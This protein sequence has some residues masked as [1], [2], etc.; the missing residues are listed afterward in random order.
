MKFS[1]TFAEAYRALSAN[2]VR[3]GLTVLGIVIGIGSVIALVAVGTGSQQSITQSIE[4]IGANLLMVQPGFQSGGA[5][6][7]RQAR[8]SAQTL[9]SADAEAIATLN[10][11]AA[12]APEVN[13]RYQVV[14]SQGNAN[15]QVIATVPAYASVRMVQM[16]QGTFLS[17]QDVANATRVVVLG[18]QAAIDLFGDPADGGQDPLG[19]TVRIKN[20]RFTVVGVTLSK[21]GAGFNNPDNNLFVPLTTGQKLL[22]GQ[23]TYYSSISVEAASQK[24]MTQLQTD[25]TDLLLAQHNISDP[26]AADFSVINQADL[27]ETASSSARTLTL[28]L[29]AIAGIS[30]VVGGIGIMNMMLTTVTERTRE[31]GLRKAI[32]AKRADISLQFLVEAVLLTFASGVIGIL[33]GWLAAL[34]L[35]RFAGLSSHVTPQSVLLAFGVSALI[36]IVFG[37]YPARRAAGL[38]PIEALRYE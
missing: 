8:G 3:S 17:E 1:D 21:G 23:A 2:K 19:Q 6:G 35:T 13:G 20:Q 22:V 5:G 26:N 32:G 36:G 31:I 4:S 7:V 10:N 28:L 33:L 29:A 18:S 38:N 12:V 24:V 37:F 9:K 15:N 30:L 34:A 14:T 27:A 16:A 25:I 11:V